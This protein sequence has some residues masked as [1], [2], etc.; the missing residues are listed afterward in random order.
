LPS[1][2]GSLE[3]PAIEGFNESAVAYHCLLADEAGFFE[4]IKTQTMSDVFEQVFPRRRTYSGHQYLEAVRDD[5]V[6][7]KAKDGAKKIGSLSLETLGI[8]A[9]EVIAVQIKKYSGLELD[10]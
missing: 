5:K 10:D 4:S 1:I 7:A 8:L 3:F 6:W 2:S 9:R